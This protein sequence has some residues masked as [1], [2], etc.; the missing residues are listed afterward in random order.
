M[1]PVTIHIPPNITSRI[2]L[3]TTEAQGVIN[4]A[5]TEVQEQ[6]RADMQRYCELPE[7]KS[8]P[9]HVLVSEEAYSNFLQNNKING[10]E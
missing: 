2:Q 1:S 6:I 7:S 9:D 3:D 4:S 10:K 5:L 8:V